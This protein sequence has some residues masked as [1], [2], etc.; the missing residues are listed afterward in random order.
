MRTDWWSEELVL[1][2]DLWL[3]YFVEDEADATCFVSNVVD[4]V[5][6]E[7][8]RADVVGRVPVEISVFSILPVGR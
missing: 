7:D 1:L 3:P 5:E 4:F 8:L 6:L 2:G